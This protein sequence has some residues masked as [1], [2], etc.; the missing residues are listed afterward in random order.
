M[1][2]KNLMDTVNFLKKNNADRNLKFNSYGQ[3]IGMRNDSA[4]GQIET[5]RVDSHSVPMTARNT[6]KPAVAQ[7]DSLARRRLY[8]DAKHLEVIQQ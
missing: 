6:E 2:K 5:N 8:L 7:K 4:H 1:K 3:R